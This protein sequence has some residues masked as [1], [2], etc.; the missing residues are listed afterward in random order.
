MIIHANRLESCETAERMP[1]TMSWSEQAAAGGRDAALPPPEYSKP[2]TGIGRPRAR[3]AF[4]W[5]LVQEGF[6][7]ALLAEEEEVL[8]GLAASKVLSGRS[9]AVLEALATE[10]FSRFKDAPGLRGAAF[11]SLHTIRGYGR[12]L[13]REGLH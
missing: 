3:L 10:G 13:G 7:A 1:L 6:G 9:V 11:E 5:N 12:T 4:I 8:E 2:R